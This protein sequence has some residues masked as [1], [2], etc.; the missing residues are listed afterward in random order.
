VDDG[1]GDRHASAHC[2][3]GLRERK[4]LATREALGAAAIRLALERGFD[5]LRVED[6]AEAAGV[7]PRTFNNYFASREQAV[8]AVPGAHAERMAAALR[9]RPV[10]EAL[11][12]ALTAAAQTAFAR[13][14]H[15]DLVRLIYR[16]PSLSA[17]FLRAAAEAQRPLREAVAER[18]GTDPEDLLPGMVTATLFGAQRVAMERWMRAEDPPPFA[19]L[20]REA[21][22]QLRVL[23]DPT[24]S[25][26][27][28]TASAAVS[29]ASAP[30]V[31]IGDRSEE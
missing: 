3:P 1:N 6:I 19:S 15:R 4:K 22:N 24:Q 10:S 17:E 2:P 31:I 16:T 11:L 27:G 29:A 7:S 5:N 13:D 20:L 25:V 12:D 14:P 30:L 21:L 18:T 8:C 23:L 28:E 26:A 9:A